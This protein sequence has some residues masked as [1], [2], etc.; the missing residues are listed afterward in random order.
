MA[1]ALTAN[2]TD[3][4]VTYRTPF[5]NHWYKALI[6]LLY[7]IVCVGCIVGKCCY[8]S[9]MLIRYLTVSRRALSPFRP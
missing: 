9:V 8:P 1:T 5:D 7:S 6:I 4:L 2:D 3:W